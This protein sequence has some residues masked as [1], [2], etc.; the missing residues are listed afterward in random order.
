MVI[1]TGSGKPVRIRGASECARP[2]W[3]RSAYLH[4]GQRQTSMRRTEQVR[5]T[6]A[7]DPTLGIGQGGTRVAGASTHEF[8]ELLVRYCVKEA[9]PPQRGRQ[10]VIT[11]AARS[12]NSGAGERQP[13][14]PLNFRT[15]GE[16]LGVCLKWKMF[17]NVGSFVFADSYFCHVGRHYIGIFEAIFAFSMYSSRA[18]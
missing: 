15:V 5:H 8:A 2:I 18:A 10:R 4:A 14:M 7:F 13:R 6:K 11:G 3:N 1:K 17:H 9:V 16:R 12:R